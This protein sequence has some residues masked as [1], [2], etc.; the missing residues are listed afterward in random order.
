MVKEREG[1]VEE[2][3]LTVRH[4]EVSRVVA[5]EDSLVAEE[6]SQVDSPVENPCE[7]WVNILLYWLNL[8]SQRKMA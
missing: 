2:A 7:R 6:D 4:P 3:A 8:S 1:K 5:V